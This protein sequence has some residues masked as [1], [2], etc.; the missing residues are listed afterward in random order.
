MSLEETSE[1]LLSLSMLMHRESLCEDIEGM[2]LSA[3]QEWFLT[4]T[5][6]YQYLDHEL[7]V[8]KIAI[9]TFLLF[10]PPS[11]VHFV[12]AAQTD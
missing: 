6:I 3:S 4:K 1:I 9:H 8:S 11:L 2:Q 10:K 7:L 12:T 5:Q